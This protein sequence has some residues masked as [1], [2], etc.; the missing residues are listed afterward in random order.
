MKFQQAIAVTGG[1]GSG[2][3]RVSR[4]LAEACNLPLYDA[5]EEVKQL[6]R[7]GEQGWRCLRSRLSPE[8]FGDDGSLLKAKLRRAIF[9]DDALRHLVEHELHPLV[10]DNLLHKIS[11]R[12][13]ACLVE[14]PLLYEAQWQRYFASV[15]VVY[16]DEAVCRERVMARDG[17]S[18]DQVMA[19]IRAQMPLVQ[20]RSLADYTIDN[21]GSWLAT[22]KQLEQIKKMLGEKGMEKK[23]DSSIR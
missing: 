8:Y 19:A 6:L 11:L 16:A 10:L 18:E 23:L 2:K 12:C 7:S 1:I 9:E 15:L 3:S 21:S 5:D 4:W 17:V 22:L 13:E 14:V 20:K